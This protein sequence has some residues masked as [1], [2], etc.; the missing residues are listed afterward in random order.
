MGTR[1]LSATV[2][3]VAL[4]GSGAAWAF[5]TDDP[6]CADYEYYY[7][8]HPPECDYQSYMVTQQRYVDVCGGTPSPMGEGLPAIDVEVAMPD[9]SMTGRFTPVLFLHGGGVAG[10]FNDI[11]GA[12]HDVN[13][14]QN[15]VRKLVFKGLVVI[16]PIDPNIGPGYYPYDIGSGSTLSHGTA[17]RAIQAF[18]C[19][20]KR[21]DVGNSL[22]PG[23]CQADGDCLTGDPLANRLAW[24][25][26]NKENVV[27]V[28]HSFGG[29]TGL[30]IPQYY[31][32][33]LKGLVLI[34]PAKD[35]G[36]GSY[37]SAVEAGTPVVH[38]YPDWY[39]PF[40]KNEP[41]PIFAISSTAVSGP[42]VPIGIRDYPGGP[43]CTRGMPCYCDPDAGCHESHHCSSFSNTLSYSEYNFYNSSHGSW[44]T[45]TTASCVGG[46]YDGALC[47]GPSGVSCTG[48]EC[49]DCPYAKEISVPDLAP[50]DGCRAGTVCGQLT[51]CLN[52]NSK[53]AGATWKAYWHGS[54]ASAATVLERYV[55]AYTACLGG[56]QG[57]GLQ[58]YVN[59]KQRQ[60]D[61]AGVG[62]GPEDMF[63]CSCP[64]YTDKPACLWAGCHW[65][66]AMDGKIIRINNGQ[67]VSEYAAAGTSN[68][69]FGYSNGVT[70]DSNGDFTERTERLSA[71]SSSPYNIAC[72][73]GPGFID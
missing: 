41:N 65:A 55:V 64:V 27:V 35:I 68:P 18:Q 70:F 50:P 17:W 25:Q 24:N 45:P 39:G 58:S 44:C 60:Y 33:A 28:G 6:T 15:I 30:Y 61:D 22:A 38:F 34:D 51:K 49:V 5:G 13:P 29:V 20:A 54:G 8:A 43:E 71:S 21:L 62:G 52:G 4:L 7:G 12:G 2:V 57:A 48:G 1:I 66:Q 23:P 36:T 46:T 37:P 40:A 14:Y 56:L 10:A 67:F 11:H 59:G 47:T 69:R 31:D 3:L 9:L 16:M 73:S 72:Q 53:P 63:A 32:Y 19:L 26:A 42:W